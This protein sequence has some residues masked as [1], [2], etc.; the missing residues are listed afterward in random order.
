LEKSIPPR[1]RGR[2][3]CVVAINVLEHVADDAAFFQNCCACLRRGGRLVLLVPAMRSLFGSIDEADSHIRRYGKADLRRLAAGSG[4]R[5]LTLRYMNL[6][7][8]IGWYYH[9]KI[10]RLRVH[11][12]GD[13]S[14]FERLVPLFRCAESLIPPPFGLSIVFAA[15]K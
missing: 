8:A 15:E 11:E 12:A 1:L 4:L 2:F 14:L 10:R 5:I 9:G 13:L 7:G 6:P 3:D